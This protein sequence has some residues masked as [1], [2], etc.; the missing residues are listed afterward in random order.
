M[1]INSRFD[2]YM[3]IY[4]RTKYYVSMRKKLAMGII[5]DFAEVIMNK[6][7]KLSSIQYGYR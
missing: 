5:M 4:L 6:R 1:S 3:V 7:G 2:M